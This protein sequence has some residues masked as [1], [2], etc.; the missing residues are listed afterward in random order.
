ML[1]YGMHLNGAVVTPD[2]RIDVI[3][4]LNYFRSHLL[5]LSG[6]PPCWQGPHT[7]LDGDR[8]TIVAHLIDEFH[9]GL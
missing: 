4:R 7:G 9:E 2:Q 5:A 3:H 1:T 8:L 6:T